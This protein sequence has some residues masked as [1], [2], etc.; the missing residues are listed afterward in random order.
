MSL[1]DD[2]TLLAHV[3]I[4]IPLT[5]HDHT[6]YLPFFLSSN[7]CSQICSPLSPTPISSTH[8]LPIDTPRH[9]TLNL[10]LRLL[11]CVSGPAPDVCRV[12]TH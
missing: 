3:H 11:S 1:S 9:T 2:I 8:S 6:L 4:H 12:Y 7:V 10:P 5:Q